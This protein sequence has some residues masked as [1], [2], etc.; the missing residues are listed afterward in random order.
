M[1][2]PVKPKLKDKK[3]V[4]FEDLIHNWDGKSAVEVVKLLAETIPFYRDVFFETKWNYDSS[5]INLIGIESDEDFDER[6]VKYEKDLVE[7]KKWR[8]E[9]LQAE[10][11]EIDGEK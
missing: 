11:N 4:I 3:V 2:K 6:M 9:K 1:K 5:D 8:I 10:I 7:W